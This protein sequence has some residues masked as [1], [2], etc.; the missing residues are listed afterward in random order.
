MTEKLRPWTAMILCSA[1]SLL[2][3]AGNLF[4]AFKTRIPTNPTM[5]FILFTGL[6]MCFFHIGSSLSR[7][8]KENLELR[9]KVD[10]LS[11]QLND[12]TPAA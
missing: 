9:A 10:K 3:I 8:Q 1:I 2:T 12:A 4:L 6:P 5:D 11:L 7:L